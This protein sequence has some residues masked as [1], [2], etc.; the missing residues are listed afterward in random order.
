MGG[1]ETLGPAVVFWLWTTVIAGGLLT[2]LA[3]V[4]WGG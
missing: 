3:I 2:M 4:I 1:R